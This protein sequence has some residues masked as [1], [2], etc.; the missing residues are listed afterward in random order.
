LAGSEER[1]A[2]LVGSLLADDELR[3]RLAAECRAVASERY[4]EAN[5]VR[6]V[7]IIVEQGAARDG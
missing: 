4:T 6:L 2:D 7:E 1:L 5:A 3:A